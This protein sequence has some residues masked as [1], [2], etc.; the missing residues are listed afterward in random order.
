MAT[1]ILYIVSDPLHQSV[2]RY[3]VGIHNNTR[4]A[5]IARYITD[6][7]EVIIHAFIKTNVANQ[8]EHIL[9]HLHT[10]KRVMNVNGRLSEWYILPLGDLI[11]EIYNIIK[12]IE[13]GLVIKK[14]MIKTADEVRLQQLKDNGVKLRRIKQQCLTQEEYERYVLTNRVNRRKNLSKSSITPQTNSVALQT[15]SVALQPIYI[16]LQTNSIPLQ[17]N[18]V[19]PQPITN[20]ENSHNV[21]QN[22]LP[23]L[24]ANPFML[25]SSMTLATSPYNPHQPVILPTQ[26]YSNSPIIELEIQPSPNTSDQQYSLNISNILAMKE[27]PKR[28]MRRRISPAETMEIEQFLKIPED[29]GYPSQIMIKMGELYEKLTKDDGTG[30][31]LNLKDEELLNGK[32]I[33]K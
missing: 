19:A 26:L 23:G 12:N 29:R 16:P 30:L 3:K 31:A 2:N 32:Y 5:L 17:T 4:K 7:P 15:N 1:D 22:S 27:E 21:I 28:N 8:V 6:L 24:G 25:Q 14:S 9:K 11:S 20:I 18:S 10:D 13:L 33:N